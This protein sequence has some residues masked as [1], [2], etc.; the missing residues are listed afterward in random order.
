MVL[1]PEMGIEHALASV[2][3]RRRGQGP[4]R[5]RG[6]ARR[7][8]T[9]RSHRG[10]LRASG[11][12][13][14]S[15]RAPYKE[16]S[17]R[18]IRGRSRRLSR[19]QLAVVVADPGVPHRPADLCRGRGA[20]GERGEQDQGGRTA[21]GGRSGL[22]RSAGRR[23]GILHLLLPVAACVLRPPKPRAPQ[24]RDRALGVQQGRH[25]AFRDL[26]ARDEDVRDVEW[27][28]LCAD[29]D[30]VVLDERPAA[31]VEAGG[32]RRDPATA[33][34]GVRAFARSSQRR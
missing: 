7:R 30:L 6:R 22:W 4:V 20:G 9:R 27:L 10:R 34:T 18:T 31:Q 25:H 1:S 23:R 5:L 17:M 28:E 3:S 13:R 14:R 11:C 21:R 19:R 33:V 12:S 15:S 2:G 8:G 16:S 26:R 29:R 24:R 32:D